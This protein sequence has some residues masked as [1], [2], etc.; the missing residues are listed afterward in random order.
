LDLPGLAKPTWPSGLGIAAVNAGYK[1][2]FYTFTELVEDLYASLARFQ[3][4]VREL[5]PY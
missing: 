1:V 2:R 5:I 4:L 3:L